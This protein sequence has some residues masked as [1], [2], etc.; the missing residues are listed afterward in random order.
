MVNDEIDLA[1]NVT[2]RDIVKTD[3]RIERILDTVSQRSGAAKGSFFM[4][5][6]QK[7]AK[8]KDSRASRRFATLDNAS[9]K[10]S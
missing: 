3:R 10:P 6:D 8:V 7:S 2:W 9:N 5:K 1:K 4:S